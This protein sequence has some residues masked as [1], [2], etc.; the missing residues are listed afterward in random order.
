MHWVLKPR[1][2]ADHGAKNM[3]VG[4]RFALGRQALAER[5]S[6]VSAPSS[7]MASQRAS[8]RSHRSII[9]RHAR[10][11]SRRGHRSAVFS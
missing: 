4:R 10:G 6:R 9:A 1:Y 8:L 5:W 2:R 7:A 11:Q 3:A